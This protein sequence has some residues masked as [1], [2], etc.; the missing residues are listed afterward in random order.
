MG[1]G[2]GGGETLSQSLVLLGTETLTRMPC[3]GAT[4]ISGRGAWEDRE[5]KGGSA[6]RSEVFL[7]PFQ[8][9]PDSRGKN[10]KKGGRSSEAC[11]FF[12]ASGGRM[13]RGFRGRSHFPGLRPI[14][15]GSEEEVKSWVVPMLNLPSAHGTKRGTDGKRRQILRS[16]R[17][18]WNVYTQWERGGAPRS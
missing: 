16:S 5:E 1:G 2:G 11:R 15:K 9:F 3:E 14:A 7:L 18:Y 6:S 10:M 8:G 12:P 17:R 13:F 4:Q